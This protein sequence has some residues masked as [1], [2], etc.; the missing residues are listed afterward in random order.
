MPAGNSGGKTDSLASKPFPHN[1]RRAYSALL[2]T[3]WDD[4]ESDNCL[5]IA[6]EMSFYFV[7]SLSPFLLVVAAMIGWL[8]STDL[9]HNFAQWITSYLPSDSRKL[10]F[11]TVLDLTRGYSGFLSVGLVG[12]FWAASSGFT[13]LMEALNITYEVKETRGYW[14]R[15]AIALCATALSAVFFIASFGVLTMG[16]WA[17]SHLL[18]AES[19]RFLRV[20]LEVARWLVTLLL[21]CVALDLISHFLPNLDRRWRWLSPGQLFVAITFV[22]TSMG[23]SLYVRYFA[24]YPRVYGALAG[25]VVLM[26]WVYTG[27][28]ILLIGAETDHALERLSLHGGSA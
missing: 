23:F 28:V 17:V 6:A 14:K 16:H 10:V 5:N 12:T 15:R 25:F 2:R 18:D 8:P 11:S 9:W 13:T 27:S 21:M 4:F 1:S 22:I 24:D 26:I 7:L 19:L 20:P 3:I